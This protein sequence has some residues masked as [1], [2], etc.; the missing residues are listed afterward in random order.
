M[1][2]TYSS[3]SG[4]D[5]RQSEIPWA[6]S[7][8]PRGRGTRPVVVVGIGVAGIGVAGV[9][10]RVLVLL[11]VLLV[12]LWW[13]FRWW[14]VVGGDGLSLFLVVVD[15]GCAVCGIGDGLVMV[16]FTLVIV[17]GA[18]CSLGVLFFV[19]VVVL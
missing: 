16:L 6:G 15:G 1:F 13:L 3:S 11:V 17:F 19:G 9:C 10:A 18:C 14:V 5:P 2:A 4:K 8:T 7:T 12:V